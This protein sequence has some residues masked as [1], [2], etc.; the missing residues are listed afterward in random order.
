MSTEL[1]LADKLNILYK[2]KRRNRHLFVT[3][4]ISSSEFIKVSTM[5][6]EKINGVYDDY[7]RRLK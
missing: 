1:Y 4:K 5:L 3:G 6:E 7:M 2:E